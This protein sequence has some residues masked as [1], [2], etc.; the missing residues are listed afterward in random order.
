M[1]VNMNPLL[2]MFSPRQSLTI[3]GF[4]V[5]GSFVFYLHGHTDTQDSPLGQTFS[6]TLLYKFFIQHVEIR[7]DLSM[8][9]LFS[10]VYPVCD[11][12]QALCL[13]LPRIPSSLLLSALLQKLV[14]SLRSIQES[15]STADLSSLFTIHWHKVI[16]SFYVHIYCNFN[17]MGSYPTEG[18]LLLP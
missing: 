8:G 14:F 3:Q 6:W 9:Q 16:L 7:F 12:P 13:F 15:K 5:K 17:E 11:L 2:Q 4:G 10:P 1:I 18:P